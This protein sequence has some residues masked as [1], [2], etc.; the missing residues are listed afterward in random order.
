MAEGILAST[1]I[2]TPQGWCVAASLAPGRQVLTFDAG[3][4][5]VLRARS[6]ALGFGSASLWPLLVPA[7]AL[8]NRDELTLLPDQKLLIEA[9]LAEDLFGDP[10]A[11]LPARAL[12][13]WRGIARC[14]PTASSTVVQFHFSAP[15]TLYASR[16]VLLSCHGGP[17]PGAGFQGPSPIACTL[18]Q[19]EHLVA[20]LIAEDAGAALR[21]V[22]QHLPR[23]PS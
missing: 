15:Q 17:L 22:G 4:Q 20:C 6:M 10:F 8:D 11:I 14:R 12:E 16:A 18:A 9:D 1:P 19:A 5:P 7:W 23:F 13:G 21:G 3:P 2:A